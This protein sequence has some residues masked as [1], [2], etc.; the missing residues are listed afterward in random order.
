MNKVLMK[1]YIK[2]IDKENV[3]LYLWYTI[4]Q[5]SKSIECYGW[6]VQ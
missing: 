6:S 3:I 2:S 4:K 1:Q 5:Y